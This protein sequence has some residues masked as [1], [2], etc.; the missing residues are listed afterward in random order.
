MRI[1]FFLTVFISCLLLCQT[2][3]AKAHIRVSIEGVSNAQIKP[4]KQQ[5]DI[6]KYQSFA[7]KSTSKLT[8]LYKSGISTI[9]N[10]LKTQG[11]YQAKV[12]GKLTYHQKTQQ[13]DITYKVSL[14]PKIR[15]K[16]VKI[17]IS[18]AGEHDPQIA[19][20]IHDSQLKAHNVFKL[21]DYESFKKSLINT[22][23]D[24]GYFQAHFIKKEVL[25]DV[26]ANYVNISI[27]FNTDDR[28]QYGNIV[29]QQKWFQYDDAFL[30]RLVPFKKGSPYNNS[31]IHQLEDNLQKSGYFNS[32]R[33]KT[34]PQ[35]KS[36]LVNVIID[37]RA[38]KSQEY[39]FGIGYGSETHLRGTIGM[40]FPHVT[41][42]GQSFKAFI[43]LSKIYTHF[44]INYLIPGKNPLTE[45]YLLSASRSK[46]NITPYYALSNAFGVDYVRK[47]HLW[48]SRLGVSVETVKVTPE[49]SPTRHLEY[50]LPTA[51]VGYSSL[52]PA[53]YYNQ[54]FVFDDTLTGGIKG[55]LTSTT[56]IKN[57][58]TMTASLSL[59]ENNRFFVNALGGALYT[60]NLTDLSP[61]LRYYAGGVGLVRGYNYKSLGPL[62]NSGNLLGGKYIL[63]GSVN[64][65]HH[66]FGDW[67]GLL[68]YDIGN[69]FNRLNHFNPQKGAGF[70]ISWRTLLGPVNFYI[71]KPLNHTNDWH[72]DLNVGVDF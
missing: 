59:N 50:L 35:V 69:A 20:I 10:A 52:H 56:F 45:H 14:G 7:L 67:S 47:F 58:L 54:G 1:R 15:I 39:L 32:I 8:V 60:H 9:T 51:S 55:P 12:T 68:Y 16:T 13:W 18:G 63:A 25:I 53:G 48:N 41:K 43:Q 38:K 49:G 21:N 11:Y 72:F 64:Y 33:V 61:T 2:T 28:Y 24:R 29:F 37:L 22:A 5:L 65:E 30:L 19:K 71:T 42:T 46:T 6:L 27:S 26:K 3:Y 34:K 66:L 40:T 17:S 70:G 36:H 4:L 57:T 23:N 31:D 44:V 62:D